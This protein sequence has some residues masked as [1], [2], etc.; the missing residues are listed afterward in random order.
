MLLIGLR[1]KALEWGAILAYPSEPSL[2]IWLLKGERTGRRAGQG[3]VT[4]FSY[5]LLHPL[6]IRKGAMIQGLQCPLE[7]GDRYLLTASK[8]AETLITRE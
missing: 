4:G 1:I 6:K 8:K 7:A 2:N 5:Y 3:G